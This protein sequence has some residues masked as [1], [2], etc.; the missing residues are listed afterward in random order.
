MLTAIIPYLLPHKDIGSTRALWRLLLYS[1][2]QSHSQ[3]TECEEKRKSNWRQSGSERQEE[4][5]R[6]SGRETQDE[7]VRVNTLVIVMK[8]NYKKAAY[9]W[10]IKCRKLGQFP[11]T[12][13]IFRLFQFS[14]VGF[15]F[16]LLFTTRTLS[17]SLARHEC[18]PYF[19]SL[20]TALRLAS[21]RGSTLRC[22]FLSVI[23]ASFRFI[24]CWI[25]CV[26]LCLCSF[27]FF[28]FVSTCNSH[29]IC[30]WRTFICSPVF[31]S[32]YVRFFFT[33]LLLEYK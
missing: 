19:L 30:W 12:M 31:S 2:I 20:P 6:E 33:A 1:H 25:F 14:T 9:M 24:L 29:R 27:H 16:K 22:A 8:R 26:A 11:N 5:R 7:R 17:R 21:S 18:A 15:A 3:N 23:L 28:V 13:H 4:R 10:R 32:T